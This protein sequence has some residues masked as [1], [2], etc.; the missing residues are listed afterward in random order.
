M[1]PEVEADSRSSSSKPKESPVTPT[2]QTTKLAAQIELLEVS[3]LATK[4][5]IRAKHDV[6][7]TAK[8]EQAMLLERLGQFESKMIASLKKISTV[9]ESLRVKDESIKLRIQKLN[10]KRLLVKSHKPSNSRNSSSHDVKGR[11]E[12]DIK[13]VIKKLLVSNE[14]KMQI[15]QSQKNELQ[16]IIQQRKVKGEEIRQ[17]TI[18]LQDKLKSLDDSIKEREKEVERLYNLSLSKASGRSGPSYRLRSSNLLSKEREIAARAQELN[19]EADLHTLS[20]GT[21]KSMRDSNK[22]RIM[23]SVF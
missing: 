12:N 6:L 13:D 17:E 15:I 23:S 3:L 22:E 4:T 2:T 18:N 16:N 11:V 7:K 10:F 14:L 19:R 20:S 5:S 9:E 1:D 8:E 21:E